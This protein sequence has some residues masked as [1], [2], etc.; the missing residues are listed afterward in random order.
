MLQVS[1]LLPLKLPLL[2]AGHTIHID[3]H[4]PR[5]QTTPRIYPA[6]GSRAMNSHDEFIVW[7]P[8]TELFYKWGITQPNCTGS[9]L[10]KADPLHCGWGPGG[11][12]SDVHIPGHPS[13]PGSNTFA[14]HTS[15][16]LQTWTW[17]TNVVLAGVGYVPN[18]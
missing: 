4:S 14:L 12:G 7:G 6:D 15:P 1:F 18:R 10:C 5:L 16:D 11:P 2:L 8:K 17:Q 9:D 13:Y 3:N